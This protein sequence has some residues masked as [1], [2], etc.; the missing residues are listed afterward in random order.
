MSGGGIQVR[1]VKLPPVRTFQYNWA[2]PVYELI[3]SPSMCVE[4]ARTELEIGG[5]AVV[6]LG[7]GRRL[8]FYL[9]NINDLFARAVN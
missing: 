6:S 5:V 3:S 7:I 2:R 4:Q 8:V 9:I 1:Q